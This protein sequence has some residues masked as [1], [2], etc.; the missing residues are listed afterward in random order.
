MVVF[1][2]VGFGDGVGEEG[3]FFGAGLPVSVGGFVV[4]H[5]EE[6][7]AGVAG[8]VEPFDGF[9]GGEVGDEALF[10]V[11]ALGV[12]DVV[13][14]VVLTLAGEDFIVVEAGGVGLEVPFADEGGLVTGLLEAFGE[15]DLG[16]VEGLLVGALAVGVA[17]ESGEEGGARGGADGVS[18][19]EVAHEHAFCGEAVDVGCGVSGGAVGGDGLSGVVVGEDED[20]VG[21]CCCGLS[22]GGGGEEEGEEESEVAHKIAP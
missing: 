13:G 20:D 12:V 18:A 2:G 1:E 21:W 19:E 17:V 7:A 3:E 15:G 14:V 4:D 6:G 22:E 8:V 9:V 5:E 10:A 16:A 11:A